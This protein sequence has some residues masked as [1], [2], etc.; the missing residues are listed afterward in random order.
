[1]IPYIRPPALNL[2]FTQL[3]PFGILTAVGLLLGTYLIARAAK[4]EGKDPRPV[5]DFVVWALVGGVIVGHLMHL[6][7]YHPEEL[8]KHPWQILRVWD[9]LSSTGGMLGGTL[10]VLLFFKW[11]GLKA[12][13][14]MDAIALGITPGWAVARLGCFLVHDHPGAPTTFPLAVNFPADVLP[15]GPRHDLGL[16]EAFVL[17]GITAVI[18]TLRSKGSLRGALLPFTVLVYGFFRFWLDFLR[19][20]DLSYVD[21]RYLGLTPAQYVAIGFMLFGSITLVL[22]MK[23][24]G[25]AAAQPQGGA[26]AT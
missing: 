23:G 10:A 6:F 17:L 11:K 22:R 25:V 5:Q 8:G 9:G 26:A 3:E 21:A 20:T 13:N 2:G 19:A 7:L 1:L 14:Y 15:G 18:W 24:R 16:Y 12:R 4:L